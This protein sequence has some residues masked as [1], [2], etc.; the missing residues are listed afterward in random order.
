MFPARRRQGDGELWRTSRISEVVC[1]PTS[2]W[3]YLCSDYYC[4]IDDLRGL[5]EEN[6][7]RPEYPVLRWCPYLSDPELRRKVTPDYTIGCK[8][9]ILSDTPYPEY[10]R[11]N[12]ELHSKDDG[13]QEITEDGIITAEASSAL[14]AASACLQE[15]LEPLD[16][17]ASRLAMIRERGVDSDKKSWLVGIKRSRFFVESLRLHD[18]IITR[19]ENSFEYEV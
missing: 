18:T 11:D 2:F 16:G 14:L 4:R 9:I 1:D 8:R 13:I 5:R 12:V 6:P 17:V 19:A 10:C 3:A 7:Q 15:L